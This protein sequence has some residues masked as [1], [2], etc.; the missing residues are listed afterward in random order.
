MRAFETYPGSSKRDLCTTC[1]I[2]RTPSRTR[3]TTAY[4]LRPAPFGER[5][6]NY[7]HTNDRQEGGFGTSYLSCRCLSFRRRKPLSGLF[8]LWELGNLVSPSPNTVKSCAKQRTGSCDVLPHPST[9]SSSSA[10]AQFTDPP[11]HIW[12]SVSS[13]QRGSVA[14]R[15]SGFGFSGELGLGVTPTRKSAL[16]VVGH[17]RPAPRARR[18]LSSTPP[19]LADSACGKT[20]LT[21]IKMSTYS[22]EDI[23]EDILPLWV[24]S[25]GSVGQ[26]GRVSG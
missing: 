1:P 15:F 10:S 23:Y 12:I 26:L 6:T 22:I 18:R 2:Y 13:G 4:S 25:V 11:D 19:F 21:T 9:P 16:L 20:T 7:P 3:V 17:R 8:R 14:S 24:K 5:V